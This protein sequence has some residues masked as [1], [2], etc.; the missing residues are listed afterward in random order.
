MKNCKIILSHASGTL[1]YLAWRV[2]KL[3]TAIF[4]AFLGEEN[5]KGEEIVEDAKSFYFD[6]ALSGS[7]NVLD[8]LLKWAPKER[9]LLLICDCGGGVE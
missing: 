5:P 4:G 9:I 7:A 8:T 6:V 2:E 3:C 1:P